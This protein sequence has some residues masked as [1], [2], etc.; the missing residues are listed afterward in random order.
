MHIKNNCELCSKPF[1]YSDYIPS[2][3]YYT[4]NEKPHLTELKCGHAFHTICLQRFGHDTCQNQEIN[5]AEQIY[6]K[7]SFT[8]KN[9]FMQVDLNTTT[10]KQF[11][12]IAKQVADEAWNGFFRFIIPGYY[13]KTFDENS[14]LAELGVTPDSYIHAIKCMRGD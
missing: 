11:V 2:E 8:G 12:I 7:N 9:V 4:Q 10:Y 3:D 1:Y 6:L 13:N 14:T 5:K